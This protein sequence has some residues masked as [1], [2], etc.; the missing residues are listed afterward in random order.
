MNGGNVMHTTRIPLAKIRTPDGCLVKGQPHPGMRG[1]TREVALFALEA[2]A[3][4]FIMAVA[5]DWQPIETVPKDDRLLMAWCPPCAEFP[6]GR[7]MIWKASIL[8]FQDHRTPRHLKFPATH[9]RPLPAP[10]PAPTAEPER[11]AA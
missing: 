7:M 1:F 4:L 3:D 2:D 8:A 6:Q 9:W 11:P 10:P 5:H